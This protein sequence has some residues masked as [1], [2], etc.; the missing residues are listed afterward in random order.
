MVQNRTIIHERVDLANR[1]E[2]PSAI[3]RLASGWVVVAD[4]QPVEG[5]CLLLSDPVVPNLNSL[6]ETGR[7]KYCLDMIRVGDALLKVT[8][9]AR[10]NYETWGNLDP[11]LHTHIVPRYLTEPSDKRTLPVC[12]GYDASLARKFDLKVDATFVEK[13]RQALAP[14]SVRT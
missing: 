7:T 13:M 10:I 2:H 14:F 1:G 11:A 8:G 4:T 9:C 6:D 12:K 3:V 5:Y